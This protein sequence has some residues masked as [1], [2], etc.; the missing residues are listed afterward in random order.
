ML[1]STEIDIPAMTATD[2]VDLVTGAKLVGG[3]ACLLAGLD[4]AEEALEAGLPWAEELVWWWR[5]ASE[6]SADIIDHRV[7]ARLALRV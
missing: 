7:P 6:R 1:P 4:R 3:Y 2:S 5:L